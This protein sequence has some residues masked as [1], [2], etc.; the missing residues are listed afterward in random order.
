MTDEHHPIEIL[1]WS[2]I[3][4]LFSLAMVGFIVVAIL[5]HFGL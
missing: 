5:L 1:E 2:D 3:A 4:L